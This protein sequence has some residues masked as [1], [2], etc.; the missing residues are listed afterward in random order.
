MQKKKKK[1]KRKRKK[2]RKIEYTP[3]TNAPW[4]SCPV[5]TCPMGIIS[6][7]VL[8]VLS[9]RG[10]RPPWNQVSPQIFSWP[11]SYSARESILGGLFPFSCA[12]GH[13]PRTFTFSSDISTLSNSFLWALLDFLPHNPMHNDIHDPF[14]SQNK[15]SISELLRAFVTYIVSLKLLRGAMTAQDRK[16][17][18]VWVRVKTMQKAKGVPIRVW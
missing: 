8:W 13:S 1:N 12:W 17:Y 6:L 16:W 5:D 11:F 15:L 9:S 14:Y 2:E 18:K 10:L 7:V 4:E 3:Q